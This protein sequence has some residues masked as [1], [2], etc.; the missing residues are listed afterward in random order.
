MAYFGMVRV[1]G[2]ARFPG[3]TAAAPG[4]TVG[5]GA[6]IYSGSQNILSFSLGGN[7][8]LDL[9]G[10][11]ARFPSNEVVG[12]NGTANNASGTVIDTAIV[13][14]AAN[15]VK[16]FDNS[17]NGSTVLLGSVDFRQT[18]ST[19]AQTAT[20]TNAPRAANPIAWVE[21]K[22]SGSTGRMAIW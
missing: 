22:V 2:L 5:N 15:T 13:R 1:N 18:A 7:D 11:Q 10:G 8:Y 19:F 3:G 17:T 20:M 14:E 6:G 9:T 16:F 12:W 21:V 4:I